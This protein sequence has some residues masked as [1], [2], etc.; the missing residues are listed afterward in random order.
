MVLADQLLPFFDTLYI[1]YDL[2]N[3]SK[4]AVCKMALMH[5][6]LG[7]RKML[8]MPDALFSEFCFSFWWLMFENNMAFVLKLTNVFFFLGQNNCNILRNRI[9]IWKKVL[10]LFYFFSTRTTTYIRGHSIIMSVYFDSFWILLPLISKNQHLTYTPS[11]IIWKN[12]NSLDL[13][14]PTSTRPSKQSLDKIIK[15]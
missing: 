11:T 8:P 13:P 15:F 3:L 2:N 12:H 14:H 1:I 7:M 5:H 6:A 10:K 9:L 4:S